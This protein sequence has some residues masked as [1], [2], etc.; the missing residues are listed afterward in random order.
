MP[1]VDSKS[2]SKAMNI[3]RE[4]GIRFGKFNIA[5]S[6]LKHSQTGVDSDKVRNIMADIES[7]KLLPPIVI[8]NDLYIID[9]HHRWVAYTTLN[10]SN[11]ISVIKIDLP[12]KEALVAF[13]KIEKLI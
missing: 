9:G 13:K 8:S 7:G 6:K 5:P 11:P 2:L 1:Q 3:M 12:Q 4:Q 10:A